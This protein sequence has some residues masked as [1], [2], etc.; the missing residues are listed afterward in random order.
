M[1]CTNMYSRFVQ[2]LVL[3][4]CSLHLC[5]GTRELLQVTVW[6]KMVVEYSAES[7]LAV[8]I[9]QTFNGKRPCEL[10]KMLAKTANSPTL[11]ESDSPA[12]GDS[13]T[14][15]HKFQGK[16]LWIDALYQP[17]SS[18]RTQILV[19]VAVACW[20]RMKW[21]SLSWAV[22]GPPPKNLA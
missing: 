20:E 7:G 11:S 15:T 10:C 4:L 19:S 3:F 1:R 12:D 5:G 8:G 2:L 18:M 13:K 22:E 14:K 9:S 21:D 6:T 16:E 17:I